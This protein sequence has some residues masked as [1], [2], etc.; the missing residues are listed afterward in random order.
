MCI[1][2]FAKN[3]PLP[4]MCLHVA[5]NSF[6]KDVAAGKMGGVGADVGIDGLTERLCFHQKELVGKALVSNVEGS[7][8]AH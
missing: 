5:I 2:T 8:F 3:K 1:G 6:F 7:L 4:S